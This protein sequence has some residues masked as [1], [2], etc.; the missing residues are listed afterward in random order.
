MSF[1][2]T[3]CTIFGCLLDLYMPRIE[4]SKRVKEKGVKKCFTEEALHETREDF[5]RFPR[6]DSHAI[7]RISTC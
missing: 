6:T 3:F 2:V 5:M 1:F 7:S 4:Q